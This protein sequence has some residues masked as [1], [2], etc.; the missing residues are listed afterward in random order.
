MQLKSFGCSFVYGTDL[1]DC[2]DYNCSL[3][4]WPALISKQLNFDYQCVAVPGQ[5]N[6]KIYCDILVNSELNEDSVFL[7]NWTWI[8]RY[9]YIDH[10]ERWQTLRPADE[11]QLQKFYYQNLHSQLHD[12]IADCTYILAAAEHLQKLK[13][14]YIMT[15]MDDLLF[16]TINPSWHNPKYVTSLQHD[17]SKVLKNFNGVNFLTWSKNNNFNISSRWH[18]LDAAHQAAAD[19][20]LPAVEQLL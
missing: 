1:S 13:I 18:P 6:F 16:E 4:T 15:Y 12:M 19:Y 20:W 2:N 17:L 9:D 14:P 7:I 11:N 10:Q 8:D 5:G 3:L